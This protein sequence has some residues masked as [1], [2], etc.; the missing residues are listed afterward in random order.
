MTQHLQRSNRFNYLFEEFSQRLNQN[1]LFCF[2]SYPHGDRKLERIHNYCEKNGFILN[3]ST[4]NMIQK[5]LANMITSAFDYG[6][7]E[8]DSKDRIN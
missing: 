5:S 4:I 1:F 6:I 2:R 3:H 8:H 7:G